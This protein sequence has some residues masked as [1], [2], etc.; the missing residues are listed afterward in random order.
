[1]ITGICANTGGLPY[2]AS[3]FASRESNAII[4]FGE[5]LPKEVVEVFLAQVREIEHLHNPAPIIVSRE[6][7]GCLYL[8]LPPI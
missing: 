7:S 3:Y 1:M 4:F 6:L 8:K 5:S 2:H